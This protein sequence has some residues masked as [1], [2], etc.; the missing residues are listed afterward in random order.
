[1]KELTDRELYQALEYARSIDEDTG[2]KMMEQFES[3]QPALVQTLFGVFPNIIAEHN[4]EM[5][6]F[7]MDLCF[8]V[9]CVF[10]K[11]FGP[12]PPQHEVD[13]DW[14]EKQAVLLD[15]ELQALIK[16]RDMD[17]K[18][19]A[20]LKD[21]FVHRMQEDKPQTGLVNFMN[22][23]I[24]DFASENTARVPAIQMTQAMIFVVI[25]LF[26]NLYEHPQKK[27]SVRVNS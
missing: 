26:D 25:R 14:L 8:D 6:Y 1:M 11:A 2:R 5:S 13:V 9:F 20:K 10:Q 23:A 15:T 24:D 21:R 16:G 19:S 18:I 22:D 12:L 4:Q 27:G 3:D 7:F 17:E